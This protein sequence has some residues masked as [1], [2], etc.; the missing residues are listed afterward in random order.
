MGDIGIMKER[1]NEMKTYQNTFETFGDPSPAQAESPREYAKGYLEMFT[2]DPDM[3]PGRQYR[4]DADALELNTGFTT[5][6]K[7]WKNLFNSCEDIVTYGYDDTA[8][9]GFISEERLLDF[10]EQA[11]EEV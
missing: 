7:W 3:G 5:E 2:I 4:I 1:L 11:V 10:L 8:K 9:S 6:I